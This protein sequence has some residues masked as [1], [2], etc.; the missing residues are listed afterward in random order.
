MTPIEKN[1]HYLC[2]CREKSTDMHNKTLLLWNLYPLPTSNTFIQFCNFTPNDT[3]SSQKR[4]LI[5]FYYVRSITEEQQHKPKDSLIFNRVAPLSQPN[6]WVHPRNCAASTHCSPPP[7]PT[8]GMTS[9]A[10][11]CAWQ[12]DTC[13]HSIPAGMLREVLLY[14]R[15]TLWIHVWSQECVQS[16]ESINC[17]AWSLLWCPSL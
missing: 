9:E 5:C 17:K 14:P 6:W 7:T 13:C 2:L 12:L 4:T 16:C 15:A 11:S 1:D 3:D 10:R 8:Q